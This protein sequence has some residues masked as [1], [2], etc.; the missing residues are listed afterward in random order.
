[1]DINLQLSGKAPVRYLKGVGERREAMYAKLG[2][3]TIADLLMHLP[4]DYIDLT[5]PVEIMKSTVGERCAVRGRIIK[6]QPE[7]RVRSKLSI[8]KMQAEDSSGVLNITIFNNRYSVEST[9]LDEEYIFYGKVDGSLIQREMT[10]PMIFPVSQEYPVLPV[11][12]QTAGLNSTYIRQNM[13]QA[14]DIADEAP[15]SLPAYIADRYSLPPKGESL[16]LIHFPKEMQQV[17]KARNRFVLEELLVLSC[18]L[19]TLQIDNK[20]HKITPMSGISIQPFYDELPFTPTG[21]QLRSITD[22]VADMQLDVPMNRL[23]QGDVGSGKTLIAAACVY[24]A[25]KNGAQAAVM[26]P[27]EI[28]AEQHYVTF[29]KMLEPFGCK[30]RLFTGSTKAAERRELLQL[31]ADG[32]VDLCVGTHALISDGVE[33][34]NL[35]LVVTDEQHRFGVTQ[36][37]KLSEKSEGAHVL[38]MSATPIPRTLSLIIYGDLSLSV[39]DELPPGRQ[40]IETLLIS[41]RK[42]ERAL[43]FVRDAIDS[44]RQAYIVC[45][46]VEEMEAGAG[47]EQLDLKPA[48]EYRDSLAAKELSGYNVGL[49]HGKMKARD[50]EE[51]MHRFKSGEIQ[52]LVSTTVVEV[53]VDVPNATIIMIENAERFGLSQLHQL[54]GRVGRGN[55]KSWCILVSDTQSPAT[56]ERLQVMKETNDGFVVAEHDL[57]LRGPGDFFGSRQHGLPELKIA[58]LAEDMQLMEQA[59]KCAAEIMQTDPELGKTENKALGKAVRAMLKSV[60]ERPN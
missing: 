22:A 56:R 15:D 28:L 19:Q 20:K 21:A 29:S 24:F 32:T 3:Y 27:T 26:A 55:E 10:S 17:E 23:V 36:R 7:Q 5:S 30:I 41:G 58:S 13:L 33:F 25:V 51:T 2:I 45:P 48:V 12:A 53:G 54:R 49:L 57:K 8:F 14:L 34:K 37:A 59:Q 9:K 35:Q 39:V 40:P 18:A 11:Y 4:R 47:G 43:G 52:A 46:L 50:K 16:R 1:M 44:G 60:G 31:L 42:R 6:K 38:V